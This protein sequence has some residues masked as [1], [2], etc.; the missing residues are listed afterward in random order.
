ME[1]FTADAP[2][3]TFTRSLIAILSV[4]QLW[5]HLNGIEGFNIISSLYITQLVSFWLSVLLPSWL[6]TAQCSETQSHF[7]TP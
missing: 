2:H 1:S 5:L 4:G 3:P 6:T 7:I